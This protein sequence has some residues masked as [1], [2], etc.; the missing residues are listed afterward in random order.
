MS[1]FDEGTHFVRLHG[2]F[3]MGSFHILLS[4]VIRFHELPQ[5]I[6]GLVTMRPT[7]HG[8]QELCL[9]SVKVIKVYI[10]SFSWHLVSCN[11]CLI[12]EVHLVFNRDTA[13]S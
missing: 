8:L 9:Q 5:D 7:R 13:A 4:Q 1:T 2:S 12:F 10:T 3:P 11:V 6:A